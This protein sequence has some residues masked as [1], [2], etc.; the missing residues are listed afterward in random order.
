MSFLKNVF[1]IAVLAGIIA[2]FVFGGSGREV[3]AEEFGDQWPF[4]VDRGVVDCVKEMA[5]TFEADG[6]VYALNGFASA[7]L[8]AAD[9]KAIAR[10]NPKYPDLDLYIGIGA[11][12]SAAKAEC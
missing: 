7:W 4:T 1:A 10:L 12:Q 2:W 6:K 5:Y 11:V 8:G 9:T 3:T